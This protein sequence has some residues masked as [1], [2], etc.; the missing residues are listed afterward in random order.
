LTRLAREVASAEQDVG[1]TPT[2]LPDP[3]FAHRIHA[4]VCGAE[5]ADV[6]DE[7]LPPGEFVRNV[8]LVADLLRQVAATAESEIAAVA[9]EAES[10]LDR[11]VIALSAG[12]VSANEAPE[13][14][15]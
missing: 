5:L 15:T 3:G 12:R 8:R 2:D 13:V 10:G 4:W 7:N 14:G 6:L 9:L 1:L 11:G